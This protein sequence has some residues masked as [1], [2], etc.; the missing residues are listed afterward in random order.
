VIVDRDRFYL[1][2]DGYYQNMIMCQIELLFRLRVGSV[3]YYE[4]HNA[5]IVQS[6]LIT[7]N[8]IAF[9]RRQQLLY[10]ASPS[11]EL[12]GVYD[13]KENSLHK[14]IDIP[15]LSSPDNLFIDT[16]NGDV[17]TALHPVMYQLVEYIKHP[18]DSR[19][20]APSQVLRIRLDKEKLTYSL[21]EPYANDGSQ[22]AGSTVAI[23][24]DRQLLIGSVFRQLLHCDIDE[25]TI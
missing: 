4:G 24:Y 9:D 2:N 11:A 16:S 1:T 13:V 5:S 7:P 10:V 25:Q 23:R 20:L 17:W 18:D 14:R 12:I 8:G 19:V 3:V 6:N 22:L 21:T 15:L